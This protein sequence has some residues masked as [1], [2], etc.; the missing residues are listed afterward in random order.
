MG[1]GTCQAMTITVFCSGHGS[2]KQSKV[3]DVYHHEAAPFR[4]RPH[5]I[6]TSIITMA[7]ALQEDTEA[8]TTKVSKMPWLPVGP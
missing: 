5:A 8:K 6:V 4:V 2:R 7:R 3:R 1:K